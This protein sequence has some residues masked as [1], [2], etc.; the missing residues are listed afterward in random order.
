MDLTAFEWGISAS[1][2][3]F[4]LVVVLAPK[5]HPAVGH[6][7]VAL[8]AICHGHAHVAEMGTASAWGYFPGMLLATGLLH[9]AGLMAG[10]AMLRGGGEW[11]LRISGGAITVV[12]LMALGGLLG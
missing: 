11:A 9:L 1:V 7:I 12:Y 10:V 8:F 3:V 5:L 6:V 2:L 4:G